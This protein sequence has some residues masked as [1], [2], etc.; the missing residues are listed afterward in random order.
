LI[1]RHIQLNG[2]PIGCFVG[3]NKIT[4]V[5]AHYHRR[6]FGS[7][8]QSFGHAPYAI[9]YTPFDEQMP[10]ILFYPAFRRH[11]DTPYLTIELSLGI[12]ILLAMVW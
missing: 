5:K 4:S 12:N 8:L 11:N 9:K 10:P 2:N 6:S 7:L 1:P 3:L